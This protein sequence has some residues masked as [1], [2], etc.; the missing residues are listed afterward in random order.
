MRTIAID[1]STKSSGI[2]VW[3]GRELF[4]YDLITMFPKKRIEE[5]FKDMSLALLSCLD[6][7]KPQKVFIEETV[8]ARNMQVQRFLTR[9]QGV[10]Y[11]WC[12]QHEAEFQTIRPTE[13][14]K[15]VGIKQG[16][17]KRDE[18]KQEAIDLITTKYGIEV[19]DDIAE[20]ICIGLAALSLY[21]EE[22]EN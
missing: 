17:K 1:A 12:V 22:K 16:K 10:V 9:L 5:R 8:V 7:Y 20:S 19:N 11:C 2:S 14:R 13:W 15:A 6:K 4:A 3:D 18:L 21:G